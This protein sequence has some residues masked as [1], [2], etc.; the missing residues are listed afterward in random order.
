MKLIL[1]DIGSWIDHCF[2][3]LIL[4]MLM[5]IV[6]IA[7]AQGVSV[8]IMLSS[9]LANSKHCYHQNKELEAKRT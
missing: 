6:A 5:L 1:M 3:C 4:L 9:H 7:I 2:W 8:V